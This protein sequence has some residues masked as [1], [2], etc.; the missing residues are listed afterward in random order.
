V[1]RVLAWGI[2]FAYFAFLG[3]LF[4]LMAN[5]TTEIKKVKFEPI[6]KQ[7]KPSK[8]INAQEIMDELVTESQEKRIKGFEITYDEA[9]MLMKIAMAEAESDGIQGKA[10][11]M[12]V[13]LNRV[14]DDRFPD[15]IEEVIFQDNQFSPVDD[16]RYDEAEPDVECHLA[17]AEIER[18]EYNTIDALY[19]EN[20]DSSWQQENC[21]YLGI[22]GHHRFYKN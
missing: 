4:Y 10:M 5:S 21:E 22:V 20:A 16:G 1:K 8:E 17:L 19:F 14:E 2:I 3:I 13:V 12:A 7:I 9:Q 15:S 18:G 6:E 11:V